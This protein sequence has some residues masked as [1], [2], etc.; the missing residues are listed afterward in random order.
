MVGGVYGAGT[1][2]CSCWTIVACLASDRPAETVL[3]GLEV[4]W[5][6]DCRYLPGE[7]GAFGLD[8]LTCHLRAY[9]TWSCLEVRVKV[10]ELVRRWQPANRLARS[11]AMVV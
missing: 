1:A 3:F 5:T 11:E 9:C 8:V 6:V 10:D 7:S 4:T 2:E